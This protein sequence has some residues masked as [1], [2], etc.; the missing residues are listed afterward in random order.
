MKRREVVEAV[1]GTGNRFLVKRN[2]ICNTYVFDPVSGAFHRKDLRRESN[3][4]GN[5]YL[6]NAT[7]E[8]VF[9][10]DDPQPVL[11]TGWEGM[12]VPTPAVRISV[13]SHVFAY[14]LDG[15]DL[16]QL[17]VS[18]DGEITK[19]HCNRTGGHIIEEIIPAFTAKMH[20]LRCGH[21]T[22]G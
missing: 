19:V 15:K 1:I 6:L 2:G 9:P 18:L 10:A 7:A 5:I 14:F 13:T 17:D 21:G 16:A 22:N 20:D 12:P 8:K 4:M 3:V 11:R